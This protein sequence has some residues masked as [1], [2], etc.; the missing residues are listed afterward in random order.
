MTVQS[1]PEAARREGPS[2]LTGGAYQGV[3]EHGQG[4]RTPL[5]CLPSLLR[6]SSFGYEGRELQRRHGGP[7][8]QTQGMLFQHSLRRSKLRRASLIGNPPPYPTRWP[9]FPITR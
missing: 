2:Q 5:T 6:R 1:C 4:A 7:F 9:F 3:H 8:G